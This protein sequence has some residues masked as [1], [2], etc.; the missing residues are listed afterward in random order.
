MLAYLLMVYLVTIPVLRLNVNRRGKSGLERKKSLMFQF[1]RSLLVYSI[2]IIAVSW[3]GGMIPLYKPWRQSTLQLF[4]SFGAGVLLGVAFLH[5]IPEAM[6]MIEERAGLPMLFG[7]LLLYVLEKFIMV[8]SC[9]AGCDVH[10]VGWSSFLGLSIHSLTAGVALGAGI[11]VPEISLMVFLAIVL[12][13]LP[14]SFSLSCILLQAKFHKKRIITIMFLFAFA[15]PVGALIAVHLLTSMPGDVIGW[16]L[17]FAGGTF[18]HIAADDL[19]PSVHSSEQ[20]RGSTLIAFL[21]GVFLVWV[22][23]FLQH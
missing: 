2:I 21:L 5:L 3:T 9:E 19:L 6:M 22:S 1:E 13:K 12:H 16:A 20:N 17:A 15:V 4:I 23:N 10:I 8:H 18:L 11:A 14:E 7:F